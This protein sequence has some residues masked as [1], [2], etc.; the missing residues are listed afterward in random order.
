MPSK[1]QVGLNLREDL[2]EDANEIKKKERDER[3]KYFDEKIGKSN[4]VNSNGNTSHVLNKKR[5][6][7]DN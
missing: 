6:R 1:P 5:D 7:K 2:V 3:K 4:V